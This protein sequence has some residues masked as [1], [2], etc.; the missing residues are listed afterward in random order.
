MPEAAFLTTALQ[1][2]AGNYSFAIRYLV[3]LRHLFVFLFVFNR[4]FFMCIW[5]VFKFMKVMISIFQLT[6]I[7]LVEIILKQRTS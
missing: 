1:R 3:S 6:Y 4:K 7:F 2:G 5:N